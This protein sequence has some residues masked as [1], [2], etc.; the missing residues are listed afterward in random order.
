MRRERIPDCFR[1]SNPPLRGM[2]RYLFEAD[3][4][5]RPYCFLG[6]YFRALEAHKRAEAEAQKTGD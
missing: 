4:E 1:R 3:I 6:D 5:Q 2:D